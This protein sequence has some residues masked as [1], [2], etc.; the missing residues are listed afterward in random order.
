V[1]QGVL[2]LWLALFSVYIFFYHT[3]LTSI[4]KAC[5]TSDRLSTEVSSFWGLY[6]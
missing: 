4:Y 1:T 6:Q 5:T 2:Y 3:N